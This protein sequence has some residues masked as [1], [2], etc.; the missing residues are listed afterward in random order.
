MS[1]PSSQGL[2]ETLQQ[3]LRAAHDAVVASV[4]G[5]TEEEAHQIPE[6]DEWTV[7]QLLAHIAEIQGFW[8][9]KAVLITRED[10]PQITRTDV[11]NDLRTA[12]VE[13][14]SQE[15]VATLLAQ[16]AAA[17]QAAIARVAEIDPKDFDRPGHRETN[18]MTVAG[19]D[20]VCGPS[21]QDPR[22]PDHRIAASHSGPVSDPRPADSRWM[23]VKPTRLPRPKRILAVMFYNLAAHQRIPP[24]RSNQTI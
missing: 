22:R 19:G 23:E 21:R 8:M 5:V 18:P 7:A 12:A 1:T 15:S 16:A 10:D 11:E 4:R 14:H 13:D 9:E 20:R 24:H 6:P 3:S 2:T 17:N